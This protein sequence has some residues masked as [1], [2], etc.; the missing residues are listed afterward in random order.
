ME[1]NA[2]CRTRLK[3]ICAVAVSL[4]SGQN[5]NATEIQQAWIY[6]ALTLGIQCEFMVILFK[7][8]VSHKLFSFLQSHFCISSDRSLLVLKNVFK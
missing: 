3:W 2:G 7:H 1:S 6:Y 8:K 5:G 4:A